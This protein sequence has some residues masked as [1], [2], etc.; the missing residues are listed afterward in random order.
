VDE[1]ITG[2]GDRPV[3][4]ADA[5]ADGVAKLDRKFKALADAS[6]PAPIIRELTRRNELGQDGQM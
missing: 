3:H 5:A 2:W 6:K 1:L 4:A